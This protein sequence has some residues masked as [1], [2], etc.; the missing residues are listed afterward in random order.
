MNKTELMKA[1]EAAIQEL[2]EI[3][4]IEENAGLIKTIAQNVIEKVDELEAE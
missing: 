4:E 1:I 3:T 2:S